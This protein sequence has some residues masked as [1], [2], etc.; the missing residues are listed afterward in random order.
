M[1]QG[2]FSLFLWPECYPDLG[3][4]T[5]TPGLIEDPSLMI[6]NSD[7][8]K[9]KKFAEDSS[10]LLMSKNKVPVEGTLKTKRYMM[11]KRL[12]FALLMIELPDVPLPC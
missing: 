2:C 12:P 1:R 8:Q 11:T 9:S 3:F 5:T 4:E 10:S 7:L 6:I